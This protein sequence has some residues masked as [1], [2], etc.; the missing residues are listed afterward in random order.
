[1]GTES[2]GF[3]CQLLRVVAGLGIRFLSV[4]QGECIPSPRV[5]ECTE[6]AL[7]KDLKAGTHSLTPRLP[8]PR[9]ASPVCGGHKDDAAGN[10]TD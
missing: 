6:Q 3:V 5:S 10:S 8:D 2:P 1:M 7:S 4:E 9:K